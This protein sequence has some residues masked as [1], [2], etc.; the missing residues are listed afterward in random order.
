MSNF[1]NKG[2]ERQF[3]KTKQ[4]ELAS[5]YLAKKSLVKFWNIYKS[6][7]NKISTN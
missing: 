1:W 6:K 5:V 2:T 4:M 3:N 7:K